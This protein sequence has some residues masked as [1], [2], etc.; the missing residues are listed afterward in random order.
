MCDVTLWDWEQ[1]STGARLIRPRE[2]R[3]QMAHLDVEKRVCP[4]PS[5][6]LIGPQGF[7]RTVLFALDE[8]SATITVRRP[9]KAE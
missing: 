3:S 2:S 6:P 5:R 4:R 1:W 7:E 9:A 8:P